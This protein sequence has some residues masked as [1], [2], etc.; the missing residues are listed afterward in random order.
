MFLGQGTY[1]YV[2]KH[3]NV[4]RKTFKF[5]PHIIQE[6]CAL[7]YLDKCKYIVHANHVNYKKKQLDMELYD[8]SLR[9]WIENNI[10]YDCDKCKKMDQ[11]KYIH[12]IIHD[13]LCGL[14]ELEDLGLA[15]A[16]IKPGNILICNKPFKAVLGDCGFVSICK[17]AKQTRTA[18]AYRDPNVKNDN[19]HDIFSFGLCVLELKY[20][21]RPKLYEGKKDINVIVDKYVK[22]NVFNNLLKQ[23]MHEKRHKR[24]SAREVLNQL[25]NENPSNNYIP[26]HYKGVNNT[27][28]TYMKKYADALGIKCSSIGSNAL[29]HYINENSINKSKYKLYITATLIIL[30]SV[31]GRNKEIVP[32][33][34]N[35]VFNTNDY[36][37]VIP[38]IKKLTTNNQFIKILYTY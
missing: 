28:T 14:I 2:E 17:Y 34:Y 7:T 26:N 37:P 15:H 8:M 18:P 5:L 20:R 12:K 1:G 9:D 32:I 25:Y 29:I 16:D 27:I 19:K 4:A 35:H 3:N 22:D 10:N 36:D 23:V 24:P 11:N 13:I 31:F 30:A 38:I 33:I 21:V 6:Y